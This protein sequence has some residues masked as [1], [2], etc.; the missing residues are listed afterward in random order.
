MA[1]SV[2]MS[3]LQEHL[4]EVL[5]RV[6]GGEELTVEREGKAAL[7]LV[8][9]DATEDEGP[10]VFRWKSFGCNLCRSRLGCTNDGRGVG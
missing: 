9:V 7:R 8:P 6:E 3:D 1:S 4:S 2:A 10:R 5:A